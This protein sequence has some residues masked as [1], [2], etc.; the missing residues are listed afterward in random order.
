MNKFVFAAISFCAS[1]ALA[2][3]VFGP[4]S[5][6]INSIPRWSNTS[7]ILVKTSTLSCADN[8]DV[9]ATG[10]LSSTGLFATTA[11]ATAVPQMSLLNSSTGDASLLLGRTGPNPQMAFGY[12]QSANAMVLSQT[13]TGGAQLGTGNIFSIN[14]ANVVAFTG[15]ISAANVTAS[16]GVLTPQVTTNSGN[17][18]LAPAGFTTSQAQSRNNAVVGWNL[19]NTSNTSGSDARLNIINGGSSGGNPYITFSESGVGS[20]SVGRQISSDD[21][22]VTS[23][24]AGT[25][26][27][28]VVGIF[29]TGNPSIP[30][31]GSFRANTVLSTTGQFLNLT[32]NPGSSLLTDVQV[33]GNLL[34]NNLNTLGN[35]AITIGGTNTGAIT[36]GNSGRAVSIPGG[37]SVANGLTVTT[38]G[39]G[40]QAG[41]VSFSTTGSFNVAGATG[42]NAAGLALNVPN[43]NASVGGTGLFGGNLRT[44]SNFQVDGSGGITM[45]TASAPINWTSTGDV[46][47]DIAGS[48][49]TFN[50]GDHIHSAGNISSDGLVSGATLS[51]SAG[52]T[53]GNTLT[54]TTGGIA[55]NNNGNVTTGGSVI[56]DAG[57][58]P[59]ANSSAGM[60][61]DGGVGLRFKLNNATRASLSGAGD[62]SLDGAIIMATASKSITWSNAGDVNIDIAGTSSTFNI[63]DNIAVSGSGNFTKSLIV[64]DSGTGIPGSQERLYASWNMSGGGAEFDFVN[65]YNGGNTPSGFAFKQKDVGAQTMHDLMRVSSTGRVDTLAGLE[66]HGSEGIVMST[67]SAPIFWPTGGDVTIDISG[68]NTFTFGD[69]VTVANSLHSNGSFFAALPNAASSGY[70]CYNT[71]TNQLTT[72]VGATCGVSSERFKTNIRNTSMDSSGLYKIRAVDFDR[73]DGSTKDEFGVIAEEVAKIFPRI[74]AYD[75]DGA[76]HSVDYTKFGLLAVMELQK[77]AKQMTSIWDDITRHDDEI[78]LLHSRI[79]EL[80]ERLARLEAR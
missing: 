36:I 67:A 76:I 55:V 7:G 10:N 15:N 11:V 17:L 8:G 72:Q 3:T 32:V 45:A 68:T 62:L 21:L 23:G 25:L 30:A 57:L 13:A 18:T 44:N 69:N 70:V 48:T 52:T 38:G 1:T 47:I 37:E 43:G 60:V 4:P 66:V 12:D 53:V 50:V 14:S 27:D 54:V 71:G 56:A 78:V 73:K 22:V 46:S 65:L 42:L 64:G 2:G 6:T 9:A 59:I 20:W 58:Y 28:S 51:S 63:G 19:Q 49:S 29:T 33:G 61:N 16:T 80:E 74:I 31:T 5:S 39:F 24:A 77:L 34:S 26:A 35:G 41:N 79:N 40:V 75:A